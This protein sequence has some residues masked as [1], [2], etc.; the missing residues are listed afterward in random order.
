MYEYR[1]EDKTLIF[2]CEKDIRLFT[3]TINMLTSTTSDWVTYKIQEEAERVIYNEK[4]GLSSFALS[5]IALGLKNLKNIDICEENERYKSI[6]G[7]IYT[8]DEG[9]LIFCPSGRI[10]RIKILD[11]ISVIDS[12]AFI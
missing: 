7:I 11:G 8:K 3:S 1:E 6:D 4:T 12:D 10:G 2:H 5:F 9:S